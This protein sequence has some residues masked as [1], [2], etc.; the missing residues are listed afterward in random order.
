MVPLSQVK[1]REQVLAPY[2]D[3]PGLKKLI[4][5]ALESFKKNN[6]L[7]PKYVVVY[8]DGGS[9]GE[10][11]RIEDYEVKQ[12]RDAIKEVA[13]DDCKLTFFVVLKKI[14]H[15]FCVG[16]C[17]NT[18][19][20]GG[21]GGGGQG[22]ALIFIPAGGGGGSPPPPPPPSAQVHLKTWV[23]GIFF[24]H[25]KKIFGAFGACHILCTCCSTC[26]PYTL[27]TLCT[28]G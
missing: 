11:K 3:G 8:R 24:S 20:P 15:D 5:E 13:G 22:F 27:C 16:G 25:G 7:F 21:G 14:R 6:K 23:L 9:E 19:T 1:P 18:C 10:L 4:S 2:G 28:M 12:I 17:P 26:A